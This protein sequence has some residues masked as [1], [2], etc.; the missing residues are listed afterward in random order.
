[1]HQKFPNHSIRCRVKSCEYHCGNADY[2]ALTAIQVEPAANGASG[3]PQDES[4]CG[5][6]RSHSV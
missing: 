3:T 6:Y 1:M 5:S 4:M 2:C